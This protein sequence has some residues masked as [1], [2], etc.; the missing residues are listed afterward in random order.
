MAYHPPQSIRDTHDTANIAAPHA[1]GT[2]TLVPPATTTSAYAFAQASAWTLAP[3]VGRDALVAEVSGL[4]VADRV[5]LL[6]LT[7]PGGVGKT[8]LAVHLLDRLRPSFRDGAVFVSL[9]SIREPDLVVPTIASALG[10]SETPAHPIAED[11]HRWLRT[12]T[13]LLVLDNLEQVIDCGVDLAALLADAPGVT[14]LVTS[15]SALAINGEQRLVVPPLDIPDDRTDDPE[16]VR[17]H[18]A[19]QLFEDRARRIDPRFAITSQNAA[20]VAAICARLDGLPLA[21]ELAA[22]RTTI[23]SPS[24]LLARLDDRLKLLAARGVDR[25]ERHRTMRQAIAWTYDLLPAPSQRLVRLLAIFV[26]GWSLDLVEALER[27]EVWPSWFP[28]GSDA[29]DMLHDLVDQSLVQVRMPSEDGEPRFVMLET[30]RAFGQEQGLALGK[31]AGLRATHLEAVLAVARATAPQLDS[32]DRDEM[33]RRIDPEWENI[34]AAHVWALEHGRP[35]QALRLANAVWHACEVKGR[36]AQGRAWH[37]S[38]MA[39][40]P[41]D[42]L[43][44]ASPDD[45]PLTADE[46][47]RS[48]LTAAFL[49]EDCMDADAAE[50]V[51]QAVLDEARSNGDRWV[52]I[53]AAIGLGLV[54]QDRADLNRAQAWFDAAASLAQKAGEYR[55]E[56]IAINLVGRLAILRMDIDAARRIFGRARAVAVRIG[57]RRLEARYLNNLAVVALEDGDADRAEGFLC[58]AAVLQ[59]DAGDAYFQANIHAN[60]G[61]VYRLRGE[62]DRAEAKIRAALDLIASMELPGAAAYLQID[63]AMI[64]LDHGEEAEVPGLVTTAL[65]S[66][67]EF[68]EPFMLAMALLPLVRLATLRERWPIAAELI[69]LTDRVRERIGMAWTQEERRRLAPVRARI[70][71][72]LP[73]GQTAA[74][75]FDRALLAA[76]G[77]LDLP[78]A[79]DRIDVLAAQL[80]DQGRASVQEP[81]QARPPRQHAFGLTPREREVLALLGQGVS[82]N[83]I[84]DTLSISARTA[85]THVSNILG[86]LGVSSRAAAV[87]V[88]VR[89]GWT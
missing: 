48:R 50:P 75:I 74:S 42:P 32:P 11:L 25:P 16:I 40:L 21:L 70:E 71:A 76:D 46:W 8:R 73:R 29:V 54:E 44:M 65:A 47:L 43:A 26:D 2:L 67:R 4:I 51:F 60:A 80:A 77:Q 61:R 66:S 17:T 82:T 27:T 78:A 15:R 5:R 89:N 37:E 35:A 68:D 9:A 58:E 13:M 36:Y 79:R 7:G 63:L 81:R 62:Y 64:A 55:L 45:R 28:E 33:F 41:E 14:L 20:A 49:I 22:A 57:D 18:A 23:L 10:L 1:R 87:A 84:A 12:R 39:A 3:L 69:D 30:V 85:T 38:A 59:Q 34:R 24:A 53:Q 56:A 31:D 19:V 6:T 83:E 88:A 72:S 86:K 52:E